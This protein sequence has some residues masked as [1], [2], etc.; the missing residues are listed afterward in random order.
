VSG[1]G[2][3]EGLE[4]LLHTF[5]NG[6][7]GNPALQR[8]IER[9]LQG[10]KDK[11]EAMDEARH[12]LESS[13]SPYLQW[14]AATVLDDAVTRKWH[15]LNSNTREQLRIFILELLM[16]K[17]P[18][19]AHLEPFVTNKLQ[20]VLI[21]IGKQVEGWPQAYPT[22]MSDIIALS[23]SPLT[24]PTGLGL[25]C[26]CSSEFLREDLALPSSRIAELQSLF[27]RE[28]PAV[29]E[30]L[31]SLLAHAHKP[32]AGS[33]NAV[34]QAVLATAALR[35]LGT[36][37]EWP[38]MASCLTPGLCASVFDLVLDAVRPGHGPDMQPCGVAAVGVMTE[39]LNKRCLPPHLEA[40]VLQ[41][42]TQMCVVLDSVCALTKANGGDD[43]GGVEG[44]DEELLLGFLEFLCVFLEQHLGR[45]LLLP[46]FPFADFC[47][48][49]ATFTFRQLPDARLLRRAFLPWTTL[50]EHLTESEAGL[51]TLPG[52]LPLLSSVGIEL[53]SKLLFSS[54]AHAMAQLEDEEEDR[55][56]V[57]EVHG[58]EKMV[59]GEEWMP[60]GSW[61]DGGLARDAGVEG[62]G[63]CLGEEK[64]ERQE[65]VDEGVLLLQSFAR[66]PGCSQ[67]LAGLVG[68]RLETVWGALTD[69]EPY[70]HAQA[71]ACTLLSLAGVVASVCPTDPFWRF[72]RLILVMA[73]CMNQEEGNTRSPAFA[74]LHRAT[75]RALFHL[76][77]GLMPAAPPATPSTPLPALEHVVDEI[78]SVVH[79]ILEPPPSASLSFKHP[80]WPAR[81]AVA[82]EAASV[83]LALARHIPARQL[84]SYPSVN[85]WI[86]DADRLA[87]AHPLS[88]Q[89]VYLQSVSLLY[90]PTDGPRLDPTEGQNLMAAYS[91]FLAPWV[92]ALP[93]AQTQL[94]TSPG[95]RVGD[96]LDAM[97][98]LGKATRILRGICVLY[99]QSPKR[100]KAF[101]HA[102][103]LPGLASLLP[104][105]RNCLDHLCTCGSPSKASSLSQAGQAPGCPE[106][107]FHS[108][109]LAARAVLELLAALQTCLGKDVGPLLAEAVRLFV[110]LDWSTGLGAA[111]GHASQD[112]RPPS[113]PSP[114]LS[115]ASIFLL[116]Y[117]LR[118]LRQLSLER[119]S[120]P[121][122]TVGELSRL[123]LDRL[124]PLV[125]SA[126]A[127]LLPLFLQL[128]GSLLSDHWREF[129]SD[130]T[131]LKT[132]GATHVNAGIASAG[133]GSRRKAFVSRD[134]ESTFERF[135]LVMYESLQDTSLSPDTTRLTIELLERLD[136][137]IALFNLEHF[138]S[139]MRLPYAMTILHLLFNR[140]HPSL[141]DELLGLLREITVAVACNGVS[142]GVDGVTWTFDKLF[143]EAL[144]KMEGLTNEQ[145]GSLLASI[146]RDI[147]DGP[148][149][150]KH[151]AAFL[152]DVRYA[153]MVQQGAVG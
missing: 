81:K 16:L 90:L 47:T 108:A 139:T 21:N 145:R 67:D 146:P 99:T 136:G 51:A 45:I 125:R 60:L 101:L 29:V 137:D 62:E 113:T 97:R 1:M 144:M 120:F 38:S 112:A 40:F 50:L 2:G 116:A 132:N 121:T 122:G 53:L 63:A 26:M 33:E 11:P 91:A 142:E 96:S 124:L 148:S 6:C 151:M 85:Q 152:S 25:L 17:R 103:L 115:P 102:A 143:P 135:L 84:R 123:A 138:Q 15:R 89:E 27:A 14:F 43:D 150:K 36:L 46:T 55:V 82:R 54:N 57:H 79:G 118:L 48:L 126:P 106:T 129:V 153:Q 114:T 18:G 59:D 22:F 86:E 31:T 128:A 5:F 28:L 49:L 83:V 105:L 39:L 19:H 61:E 3:L 119:S 77:R 52:S 78:L 92:N 7:N 58:M 87:P 80:A 134:M 35:C 41:V 140:A 56:R 127:D 65:V 68:S 72:L 141:R 107:A 32:S 10:I 23:S 20:Q 73:Q 98:H 30:M 34:Q 109:A 104:C 88:V 64:S 130:S 8:D 70:D 76:T 12:Y 110:H 131:Y 4:G 42:A 100:I 66:L 24:Y 69:K 147:Q 37:V 149:F 44:A 95:Q 111:P 133:G 94:E 71:D 13:S 74:R 9:E 93:E 117:L 75:F